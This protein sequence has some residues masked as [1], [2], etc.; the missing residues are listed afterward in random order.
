[1]TLSEFAMPVEEPRDGFALA[2]IAAKAAD[3]KL[4]ERT[5]VLDVSELLDIFDA[6]VITS[7]QTARQVDAIVDAIEESTK[8]TYGRGPL[9]I[10]GRQDFS[11]V[12]MD[13]GDVLIHVFLAETRAFYDLEHLWTAAPRVAWES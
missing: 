11:W 3:D 12:L 6:F 4:A 8:A 13:Y 9:R 1:M 5:V 7:G 2:T 10:E